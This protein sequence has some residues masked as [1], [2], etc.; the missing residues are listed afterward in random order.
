MYL[1]TSYCFNDFP[2]FNLLSSVKGS[3]TQVLSFRKLLGE[4]SG[5]PT[6]NLT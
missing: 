6:L 1:F 5:K 2:N 4:P 3:L